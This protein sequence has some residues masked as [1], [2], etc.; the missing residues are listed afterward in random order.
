M[1]CWTKKIFFFSFFFF[2][3]FSNTPLSLAGM[4]GRRIREGR[5]AARA[6][7]PIPITVCSICVP[8]QWYGSHF[9]GSFNVRKMLMHVAAHGGCT[10]T[11]RETTPEVDS[12]RKI[13]CRTGDSNPSQYCSWLFSRTFCQLSYPCPF[14][15]EAL[16]PEE[17]TRLGLFMGTERVS[18]GALVHPTTLFFLPRQYIRKEFNQISDPAQSFSCFGPHIWNLLPQD[19]RHCSTLSSFEAKMKTFLF[20]QYFRP[21]NINTQFLL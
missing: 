10:D 15:F 6:A 18:E 14:T 16:K 2:F 8:T 11:V 1:L 9:S 13:P 3:F 21:T 5:A 17:N 19:L 4:S 7:P 20:S 12:G